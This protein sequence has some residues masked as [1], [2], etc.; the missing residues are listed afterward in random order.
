MKFHINQRRSRL[1]AHVRALSATVHLSHKQFIQPLFLDAAISER[2]AIPTLTMVSTDSS[3]SVLRQVASDVENG[4]T[5]FLL[6]PVPV[7]KSTYDFDYG[8][9]TATVR[10]IKQKFG[11]DVWLAADLCLCSYTT[12]GHCGILNDANSVLVNNDTVAELVRYALQL[13]DAGADCIAPSDMSDGRISAIRNALDDNGYEHVSILSYSAKFASQ[14]YAPFRDVCR[15]SP[16]GN[17]SLQD[18]RSYQISPYNPN[19]AVLSTI[20][21][22]EEGAD[23]VMVKPSVLY[24]DV[25]AQLRAELKYKP[26]AAYHVSGEYQ[27]VELLAQFSGIPRSALHLEAW[28]S[29]KRAGAD[30]IISYAARHAHE[31]LQEGS[32]Y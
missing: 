16:A 12:H 31:W 11:S 21:D 25:I 15:S 23:M 14:Y 29:I 26:I 18:R 7:T 27:S 28:T 20:R 4:I 22:A 2:T 17:I 32:L 9:A 19:D 1:N 6:F 13:A 3:Q 8:F 30:I 24:L 10:S 5:K